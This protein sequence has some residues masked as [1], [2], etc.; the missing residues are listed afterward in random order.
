MIDKQLAFKVTYGPE[1]CPWTE[2]KRKETK[3][4]PFQTQS[5]LNAMMK[6]HAEHAMNTTLTVS[7]FL[8]GTRLKQ[9]I[10]K[11]FVLY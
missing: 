4:S 2:R 6:A 9:A 1:V 8:K 7:L 10:E 11:L 3:R 5:S